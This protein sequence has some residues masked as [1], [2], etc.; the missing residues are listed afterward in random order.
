MPRRKSARFVSLGFELIELES[1]LVGIATLLEGVRNSYEL[2]TLDGRQQL[3]S[4]LSLT[5]AIAARV[6]LAHRV[7]RGAAPV[8][9]LLTPGN[10]TQRGRPGDD[11]DV[12]LAVTARSSSAAIARRRLA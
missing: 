3:S 8:I 9:E 5:R 12:R 6:R 7:I 1:G 10:V 4:A 2:T 11:P